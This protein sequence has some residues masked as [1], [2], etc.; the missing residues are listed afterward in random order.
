MRDDSPGLPTRRIERR[1]LTLS[2]LGFGGASIGNLYR[3]TIDDEAA[4]AVAR[5]WAGGVRY[6]DTAPH[7]G[8]GLSERRLGAALR[9]KNRDDYVLSTKVGRLLVPNPKPQGSDLVAGGF[10]VPDDLMR[11]FDFSRDGVLRSLEGSLERLGVDRVDIVYV[12]DPENHMDDAVSQA[13]PALCELRDQGVIG[14]IGA[15]MNHVAPLRR[16]VAEADVDVLMVAGRW[17]LLDRS[18][19]T[20]L[21]ECTERSVAVV[22]AAPFNSGLLAR[23][24]PTGGKFDYAEAST[25]TVARAQQLATLCSEGGVELPAAAIQ[26]PLREQAVVSVV[27]GMRNP[28]EVADALARFSV[29]V[30]DELWQQLT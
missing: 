12:H 19:A 30:P 29:R 14:A 27:S 11:Q 16:I 20:L 2:V 26:F 28:A 15:G 22:D 10:D 5:A 8:L 23:A 7:Y 3:N 4:A 24:W 18:A 17:T 25:E 13:L 9:G 6:F 1:G 21:A